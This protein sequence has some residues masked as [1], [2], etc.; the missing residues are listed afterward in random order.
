M[1]R[2][3]L[4]AGFLGVYGRSEGR[5]RTEEPEHDEDG[6]IIS[7]STIEVLPEFRVGQSFPISNVKLRQGQTQPPGHLTESE[8][9]GL[10]EKHG[11]GTDASIATHINNICVRNYVTLGSGRTLVPTT[12]GV[13]LVHGTVC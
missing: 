11:I 9:I 1:G 13:V 12:L 2:H 10:M 6:D 3:E 8:L 7:D 5:H 4:R